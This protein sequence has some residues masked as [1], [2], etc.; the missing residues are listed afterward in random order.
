MPIPEIDPATLVINQL[1]VH[2]TTYDFGGLD[3]DATSNRLFGL[4]DAPST[5]RGLYEINVPGQTETLLA[6]Y[7]A[8]ETDI[9]GLAVHNGL[10]Y[11]VT[12]GPNTTQA[13]FYIF[14]VATGQEVG[15]LPSPFTAGGTFSAAAYAAPAAPTCY[16]DCDG[17]IALTLADFGCFQTKFALTDPYADCNGDTVLNLADFGCFQ[18]AYALGCP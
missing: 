1:Y 18:T 5:A 17:D 3:V 9:D 16:P 2:P 7:P 8:G 12:D 14:D 10:A 11:Y 4:S 6:P 13:S 15:T